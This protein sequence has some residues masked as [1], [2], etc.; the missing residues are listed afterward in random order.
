MLRA[1]LGKTPRGIGRPQS[2]LLIGDLLVP[3]WDAENFI[4]P[5]DASSGETI[6]ALAAAME[7]QQASSDYLTETDDTTSC[8]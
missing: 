8:P 7:T 1:T 2:W 3:V 4:G 6:D 5:A